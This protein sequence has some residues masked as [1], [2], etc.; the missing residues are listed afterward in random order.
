MSGRHQSSCPRSTTNACKRQMV[1]SRINRN[2][3]RSLRK[4]ARNICNSKESVSRIAKNDMN[5][6]LYKMQKVHL[7]ME[8][9]KEIRLERCKRLK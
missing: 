6:H 4:M 2:P 1:K 5:F 7:L 9:M 3:H 8:R